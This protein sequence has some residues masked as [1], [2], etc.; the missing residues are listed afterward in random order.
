MVRELIDLNEDLYAEISSADLVSGQREYILPVDNTTTTYGGG[1]VKMQRVEVNYSGSSSGWRIATPTTLQE[2]PV[3]TV[4]GADLNAQYNI[5]SPRYWFK[6]RSLWLAPVPSST[7]AVTAGNAGLFMYWVKRP[8]EMTAT[9]DIP[10][11]PKD[12]LNVLSEGMMMDI[13]RR[14]G[15]NNDSTQAQRNWES[16]LVNMREKE[17]APDTGQPLIFRAAR[18]NYN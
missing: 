18:K 17:Q 9:T 5:T 2:I 3:P 1:L 11:L 16:G 8:N 14:Y 7:D 6:D 13:F 10:D 15:R 12:F 4:L